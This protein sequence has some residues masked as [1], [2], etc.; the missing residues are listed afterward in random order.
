MASVSEGLELLRVEFPAWS[1]FRSDVGSLYATR[2]G[3]SLTDADINNGLHQTVAA[4]D[5]GAMA[6]LLRRQEGLTDG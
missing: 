4:D 5:F 6:R 2:R 3:I 1:V